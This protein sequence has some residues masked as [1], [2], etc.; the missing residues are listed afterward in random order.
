MDEI[1]IVTKIIICMLENKIFQA[2]EFY[3]FAFGLLIV[4]NEPLN[5]C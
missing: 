4:S 3:I 1:G 5:F 2:Q